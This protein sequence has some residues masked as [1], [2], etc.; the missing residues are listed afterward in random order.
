MG[1]LRRKET[2][3]SK[4]GLTMTPKQKNRTKPCRA[5]HVTQLMQSTCS[6][7][8]PLTTPVALLITNSDPSLPRPS[9]ANYSPTP[10]E[11][12]SITPLF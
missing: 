11:D 10:L 5:T 7:T 8:K 1:G 9:T 6:K 2:T 3:A 12:P 4:V